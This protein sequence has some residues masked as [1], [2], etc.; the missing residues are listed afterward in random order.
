LGAVEPVQFVEE[1][2]RAALIAEEPGARALD[3]GADVLDGGGGGIEA[4]EGGARGVGDD[5]GQH[6]LP[7]ARRAVEDQR[8]QP[9]R[10]QHPAQQGPRAEDVRLAD[11]LLERARPHPH[12]ER[13]IG[14]DAPLFRGFK[15]IRHER[16]DECTRSGPR[17]P[18]PSA[19]ATAGSGHEKPPPSSEEVA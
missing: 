14:E 13:R 4:D 11:E 1:E 7:G 10:L 15:Q 6:R 8:C 18:A 16:L 3:D 19:S 5:G 17:P 12:G 2:D 9:V